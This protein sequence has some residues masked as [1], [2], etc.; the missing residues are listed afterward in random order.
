MPVAE[1]TEGATLEPNRV[2]VIP[3]NAVMRV[4]EHRIRLGP[5]KDALGPPMPVDDLLES[6]AQDDGLKPIG[7]ILSGSGSDGALGMQRIKQAGGLTF[8]QDEASAR[9][10]GMPGA[11]IGLGGSEPDLG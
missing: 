7:V 5:R 8:A 10:N 3:P 2:Y 9:F 1:A 11:A 6:L 4:A